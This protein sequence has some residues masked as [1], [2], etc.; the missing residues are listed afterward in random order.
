M[1][2][3]IHAIKKGGGISPLNIKRQGEILLALL[4]GIACPLVVYPLP[5]FTPH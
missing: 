4:L 5:L 3:P 1:D 2:F